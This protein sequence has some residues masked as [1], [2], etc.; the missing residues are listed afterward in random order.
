VEDPNHSGQLV[1]EA[2]CSA[3]FSQR[4]TGIL[5]R[6]QHAEGLVKVEHDS[7]RYRIVGWIV[8]THSMSLHEGCDIKE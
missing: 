4:E 1:L 2:R 8:S 3:T 6:L 7:P 5:E